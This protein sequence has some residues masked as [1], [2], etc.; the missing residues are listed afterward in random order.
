MTLGGEAFDLDTGDLSVMLFSVGGFWGAGFTN[1][2]GTG[3]LPTILPPEHRVST[4]MRFRRCR[5]RAQ[6]A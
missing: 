6:S 2:A 1:A 4:L 5:S 3:A